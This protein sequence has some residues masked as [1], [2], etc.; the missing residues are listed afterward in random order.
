MQVHLGLL[1]EKHITSDCLS[2]TIKGTLSDQIFYEIL[3]WEVSW[4]C[5]CTGILSTTLVSLGY[6][7]IWRHYTFF[8]SQNVSNIVLSFMVQRESIY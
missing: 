1:Y 6:Y 2:P 8:N 5:K 3:Y 4:K 7:F